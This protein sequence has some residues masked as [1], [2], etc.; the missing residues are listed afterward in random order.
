MII[1]YKLEKS[2][3]G[4]FEVGVYIPGRSMKWGSTGAKRKDAARRRERQVQRALL[5]QFAEELRYEA[6]ALEAQ[7]H[8]LENLAGA[9]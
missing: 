7:A 9:R 4:T 3:H 6:K 5:L 8:Q 2:A 1:Q